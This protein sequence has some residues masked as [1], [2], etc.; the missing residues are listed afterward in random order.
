MPRSPAPHVGRPW[1]DAVPTPRFNAR[2]LATASCV[3]VIRGEVE[4]VAREVGIEGEQLGR[5]GLAVSEAATNAVVHGSAGRDDAYVDLTV[6][7]SDR[8][9]RVTISD[10]GGGLGPRMVDGTGVGTGLAII[11]RLAFRRSGA[12]ATQTRGGS[13]QLKEATSHVHDSAV[14]RL[15]EAL[16]EQDRLG[17]C[18]DAAVG[19]STEFG[20]YVRLQ[21]AGEQVRAR[22]TWLNWVENESYRGINAGP[23]ELAAARQARRGPATPDCN[24]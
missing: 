21:S 10:G 6:D 24:G 8:E 20:A 1:V 17:M 3:G 2:Y 19:T 13:A 22:Q 14:R 7:L 9:M 18:F 4:A 16:V 23:L 5:V 11:V 15:E 12:V